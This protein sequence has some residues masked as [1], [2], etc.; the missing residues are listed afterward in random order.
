MLQTT[1]NQVPVIKSHIFG[2]LSHGFFTRQGGVSTGICQS[3]NCSFK[4]Y[5]TPENVLKNRALA[6]ESLSLGGQT[7][8][9]LRQVHEADVVVVDEVWDPL[10]PPEADALVTTNSDFVLGI[11]TADCVPVLLADPVNG[12]IGAIHAGW[13]GAL[14][15]VVEATIA[16]MISLGA[17]VDTMVAAIGPCIA[18]DSYEVG[19]EVHDMFVDANPENE[20][21][22]SDQSFPEAIHFDLPAFVERCLTEDGIEVERLPYDTYAH[23]DLFFSCRR[24]QHEKSPGFGGHISLISLKESHDS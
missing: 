17:S 19:Q 12:V 10:D 9:V 14:K 20:C 18:Q 21:F 1:N 11:Q 3:L 4:E 6:M 16:R 5:D 7:L 8:V 15:G 2:A 24:A 23:E 13:R 22:F